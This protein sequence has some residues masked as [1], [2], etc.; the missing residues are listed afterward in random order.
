MNPAK[1][2]LLSWTLATLAAAGLVA[3]ALL[4]LPAYKGELANVSTE[5]MASLLN[6][7]PAIIKGTSDGL[8][9]YDDVRA[10]MIDFKWNAPPPPKAADLR[11][12][13]EPAPQPVDE[14]I[15]KLV[16]VLGYSVDAADSARS[17]A[18]L[19]YLPD[20]RVAPPRQVQ[21]APKEGRYFRVGERLSAPIN[22]IRIVS[23]TIAGVEFGFD[24]EEREHE[25]LLPADFDLSSRLAYVDPSQL[26]SRPDTIQ[27]SSMRDYVAP[28]T[29]QDLGRGRFRLGTEDIQVI[30]EDYP[31]ILAE[32][33]RTRRHRDPQTGRYDGIEVT[34][35]SP[36]SV[37]A[38][39]GAQSGDVIK[40]ING[41][42]VTSQQEA[43][44]FVKNNGEM[45]EKWEIVV[46]NKGQERSIT[47]LPPKK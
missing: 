44:N 22:H 1:A 8:V 40:S 2:K 30:G 18:I 39:H 23:I 43:I 25:T 37:A 29:T 47:Y 3:F 15:G 45:Y 42:P 19:K 41:H 13:A 16:K 4:R 24:D 21:G 20:S 17:Q 33:V 26:M 14:S 34:S 7:T 32:E 12:V 46:S 6:N 9:S 10:S 11:K 35:V 38:R 28:V 31:R 27:I 5:R 36:G